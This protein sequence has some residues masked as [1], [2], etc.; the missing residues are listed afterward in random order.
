MD[1]KLTLKL[2][3]EVIAKAKQYAKDHGVSLSNV[4]EDYLEGLTQ[5]KKEKEENAEEVSPLVQKL[6]GVIKE[7]EEW[8]NAYRERLNKKYE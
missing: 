4:V 3:K 5:Y 8:K 1:T 7:E 2:D 6:S